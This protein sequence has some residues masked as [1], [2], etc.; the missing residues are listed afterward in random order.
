MQIHSIRLD[1]RTNA[2]K[3]LLAHLLSASFFLRIN[4]YASHKC[5][6]H[7]STNEF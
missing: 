2:Q 3:P 6:A 4:K 5:V 7:I 1:L